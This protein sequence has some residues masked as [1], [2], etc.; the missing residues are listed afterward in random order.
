M[1]WTRLEYLDDTGAILATIDADADRSAAQSAAPQLP[2]HGFLDLMIRAQ[3]SVLERFGGMLDPVL[4]G[5]ARIL[6]MQAKRLD[7]LEEN[8]ADI[9]E[10][11]RQAAE[12]LNPPEV[13]AENPAD[14]AFAQVVQLAV[15]KVMGGGKPEAPK[16]P[17]AAGTPTGGNGGSQP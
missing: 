2:E 12:K 13:Q 7:K 16:L 8:Y 5:Y 10:L 11:A 14:S 15:S 17:Q 6:D 9:L 1:D 4:Q 3:N